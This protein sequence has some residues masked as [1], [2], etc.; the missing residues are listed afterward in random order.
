[1]ADPITIA[2]LTMTAGQALSAGA[3][4]VG[5]ASA[6]TQGI[7]ASRVAEA[8]AQSMD[9]QARNERLAAK[10]EEADFR[11][12][13]SRKQAR[14]RA[15]V[16]GSGTTMAG[17]PLLLSE[18]IAA[19]TELQALRIRY[20]GTVA[21]NALGN[22]AALERAGGKIAKGESFGRAGASLLSGIGQSDWGSAG[23]RLPSY[24]HNPHTKTGGAL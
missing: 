23:T 4:V 21:S 2:G 3:A 9:Q 11:R 1:M 10:S 13:Q 12:D 17:S 5:A 14:L 24:P 18:D 22:Q 8:N 6:I 15:L 16:G 19:E 7:T 20:G